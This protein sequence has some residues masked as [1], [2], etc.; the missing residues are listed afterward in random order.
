MKRTSIFAATAAALTI[1]AGVAQA[2]EPVVPE[3]TTPVPAISVSPEGDLQF[4]P[5]FQ[6]VV[7][8]DNAADDD[9]CVTLSGVNCSC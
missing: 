8:N 7:D 5:E 2:S 1:A 6:G 4:A 9:D 3:T